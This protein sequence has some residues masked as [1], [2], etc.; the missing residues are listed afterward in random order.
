MRITPG[1][2]EEQVPGARRDDQAVQLDR[3]QVPRAGVARYD[4]LAAFLVI[5]EK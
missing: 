5:G 4:Q 1:V 2:E 3:G